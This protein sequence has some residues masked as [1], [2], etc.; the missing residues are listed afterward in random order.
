MTTREDL[1]H[2]TVEVAQVHLS[3]NRERSIPW[4]SPDQRDLRFRLLAA[5]HG[6]CSERCERIVTINTV[7]TKAKCH[8]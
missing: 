7:M 3:S 1:I 8:A 5:R 6:C 2:E 4:E